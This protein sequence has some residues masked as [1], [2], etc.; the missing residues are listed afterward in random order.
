MRRKELNAAL[1]TASIQLDTGKAGKY[2]YRFLEIADNNYNPDAKH[3]S[4]LVLQ[5]TVN[6]RP[7]AR[8][9]KPGS[10]YSYCA[11]ESSDEEFIPIT[12]TGMPPFNLDVDLKYSGSASP[13]SINIPN[14]R[15]NHYNLRL[16]QK[17]LI[18]GH[19]HLTIRRVRDSRGCL[20]KVDPATPLSK[21]Q[22]SVHD[23]PSIIALETTEHFC[24]GDRLSFRLSGVPPFTVLYTFE[25]RAM[26]ATLSSTTFRRLAERSGE[27]VITGVSDS[28]SNCKFPTQLEKTIHPLPKAKISK[29]RETHVDIHEGSETEILFEFTGTPPFE[30]TYTRSENSRKSKKGAVLE[31]KTAR[32]N[33]FSMRVKASEEGTY[34]VISVRDKWCA[35]S[36]ATSN[37]EKK[38]QKLLT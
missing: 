10:T 2:E 27:F 15:S 18:Q 32:T 20:S 11:T 24:I 19:S 12:F 8:F 9:T 31:T 35:V 25:N 14:I 34:E 16:P 21:V 7:S 4:G 29:G 3:Q 1:G 33:E 17:H 23:P 36:R 30:F 37:G 5:Q 26:K 6:A 28:G 38:G 13:E 22:I